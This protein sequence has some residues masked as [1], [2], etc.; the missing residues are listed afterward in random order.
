MVL[1]IRYQ[2]FSSNK[3]VADN[4]NILS[5]LKLNRVSGEKQHEIKTAAKRYA[6]NVKTTIKYLNENVF[7]SVRFDRVTSFSVVRK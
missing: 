5:E 1:N 4:G 3:F 6:R 7:C 2:I